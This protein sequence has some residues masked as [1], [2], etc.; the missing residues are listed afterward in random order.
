MVLGRQRTSVGDRVVEREAKTEAG[1]EGIVWFD[2]YPLKVVKVWRKE[3]VAERLKW[4]RRTTTPAMCSP[5][6]K[7]DRCTPTT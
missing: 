7:G 6:R 2:P 3:Q 5:T 1:D 4:V